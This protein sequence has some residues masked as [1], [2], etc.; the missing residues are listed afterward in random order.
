MRTLYTLMLIGLLAFSASLFGATPF[1]LYYQGRLTNDAGVPLDGVYQ[2]SF[3]V[4]DSEFGGTA[5]WTETHTTVNVNKGLFAV[6]LGSVSPIAPGLFVATPRFL[7]IGVNGGPEMSTRQQIVST[8][9]TFHSYDS[10]LLEGEPAS[11][12]HSWN[13]LTGMPGGFAD[14]VDDV[15]I[16]DIT[17]VNAGEGLDGGATT[18]S[19]TLGIADAGVTST[20]LLDGTI[21]NADINAAA[22]IAV[23]KISGTAMNLTSSQIVSAS[24]TF[25]GGLHIGDTTFYGNNSG[26]VIGTDAYSPSTTYLLQVIRN[27]STTGS[28]YGIYA[29]LDNFSTGTVYGLRSRASG[30]TAGADN[31]G[32]VYGFYGVGI[33]DGD[34]RYGAYLHGRARTVNLHTGSSY[35]FYSEASYGI[36]AYG[37]E[38]HATG[39]IS[40]FGL[41]AEVSGNSTG[42]GVYTSVHDNT[43][44]SSSVGTTNYVLNN[45]GNAYGISGTTGNNV[46]TGYAVYGHSYSNAANWSGYFT[47][48]V[49]VGGTVYMP[50]KV[51]RLDHPSDPENQYLQLAGMESPEYQINL[52]GNVTTDV[53]G[54]A[55]VS[56]PSYLPQIA[57]DFR[58]HLTVIGQ[59][60]QAIVSEEFSG[61]GFTIA[62]DQ[63]SVKVSWMITGT[64][65]DNFAKSHPLA[66]E[67][68]KPAEF[69]GR[70]LHPE[71]F[72][73]APE[74]GYTFQIQQDLERQKPQAQARPIEE[75]E[76]SR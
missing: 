14:G 5:L 51:T 56:V 10:D 50:A 31:A 42:I 13:N 20:H 53:S 46:G 2:V 71:A 66:N 38:L 22:A 16:G 65:T 59:F 34:Y 74:R 25:D 21:T 60:A 48:D 67:L 55:R 57:T 52:S 72:G 23:G 11:H 47:G 54:K 24:K 73:A 7:A 45:G 35:G 76:E 36:A 19:A 64:R 44:N 69:R 30:A 37:A 8:A 49:Y 43:A 40:G 27:Y 17:A 3:T 28:R 32:T 41:F 62:T 63:P 4:Y 9:Y 68:A 26:I 29:D 15:G 70:Y 6:I 61:G 39:A 58:Y 33:S 18:G 1:L 75:E 12:Y